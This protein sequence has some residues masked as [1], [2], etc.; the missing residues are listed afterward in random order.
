[1]KKILNFIRSNSLQ[2]VQIFMICLVFIFIYHIN[3]KIIFE[4][5]LNTTILSPDNFWII[6]SLKQSRIVVALIV[7][8]CILLYFRK[9]NKECCMNEKNYYHNYWYAWYWF[10]SN[11]LGI[12]KCNLIRVPIFLQFKLV[13]NKTF[14]EFIFDDNDFPK[15]ENERES[16]TLI[17]N[18]DKKGKEINLI[19]EDTYKLNV[20]QLPLEKKN[21]YTI[22]ISRNFNN[23]VSR[24]FSLKFIDSISKAVVNLKDVERVNIFATTNPKNT[25]YIANKVFLLGDRG[26]ISHLYVYQQES[27]GDRN[28]ERD[29]YKIY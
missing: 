2:L 17:F 7:S 27:F 16:E 14:D 23:D 9:N 25:Y 26:N 5:Y 18:K 10:C 8:I 20:S 1:M 24:H 19:L 22:K 3:L 12:K 11:I 15:V 29:G 4:D 13:S 21:L 6:L 28:F